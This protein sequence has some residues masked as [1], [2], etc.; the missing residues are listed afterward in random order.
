[1]RASPRP[2]SETRFL[3]LRLQGRVLRPPPPSEERTSEAALLHHP[4]RHVSSTVPQASAAFAASLPLG[5][6]LRLL[7]TP[8][9]SPG[10]ALYMNHPKAI[11]QASA[12]NTTPTGTTRQSAALP[13]AE[14]LRSARRRSNSLGSLACTGGFL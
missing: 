7:P 14:R 6:L 9:P 3:Q 12:I 10:E 8:R 4:R 1:M 11:R 13:F 2:R 5:Q